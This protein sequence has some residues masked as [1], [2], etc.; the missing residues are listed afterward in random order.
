MSAKVTPYPKILFY[1]FHPIV[2][3]YPQKLLSDFNTIISFAIAETIANGLAHRR[4]SASRIVL[5]CNGSTAVF[6]SACL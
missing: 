6:G 5:W 2:E 1:N 3:K 4:R